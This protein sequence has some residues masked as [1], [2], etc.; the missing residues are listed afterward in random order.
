VAIRNEDICNKTPGFKYRFFSHG[1]IKNFVGVFGFLKIRFQPL[2]SI[3]YK[4]KPAL[5]I[6]FLSFQNLQCA[7]VINTKIHWHQIN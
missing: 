3:K 2:K 7:A 4:W 1:M 5:A 6:G